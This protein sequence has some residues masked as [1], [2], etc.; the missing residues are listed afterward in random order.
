MNA[1]TKGLKLG[2]ALALGMA[3]HHPVAAEQSEEELAKELANPVADLVSVPFQFNYNQNLG[4]VDDGEQWQLNIQP[5]VPFSLSAEWNLISRTIVPLIHQSDLFPGAGSQSGVG[6]VL[7]SL[8]F[9]PTRPTAGGLIWGVGPVLLLP[10]GSNDLLTADQWAAGPTAVALQQQGPWTVGMLA[11]HLWSFAGDDD[12]GEI[13]TT[14][15]QPFLSYTTP[16]AWTYTLQSESFYDWDDQQWLVPI[17][18]V[19]SKVTR[20]GGQLVSIGGGVNYWVESPDGGPEGWGARLTITLL[21]P[22]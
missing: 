15:L 10:T 12:R 4:P 2:L 16:T 9:S 18:A 1:M 3:L 21:F 6:D 7:Q 11:N 8:F 19:V 20:V 17:R 22:R 14:F 5:V 13:N